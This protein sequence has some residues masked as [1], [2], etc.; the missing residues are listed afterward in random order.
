MHI[1]MHIHMAPS[2]RKQFLKHSLTYQIR[3]MEIS[4]KVGRVVMEGPSRVCIL[5]V[6]E[7]EGKTLERQPILCNQLGFCSENI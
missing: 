4:R 5:L 7:N 1:Y 2:S 3:I 6:V